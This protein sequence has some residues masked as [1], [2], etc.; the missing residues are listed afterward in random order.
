[1]KSTGMNFFKIKKTIVNMIPG[2]LPFLYYLNPKDLISV[3]L[4]LLK[5]HPAVSLSRRFFIVRQLY[6]ISYNV[7][8]RH[9]ENEMVSFIKAILS[10]P[11]STPGCIIEAGCYK[12]GSTAKFSNAA[13]IMN[14]RLVIFDSFEGLPEHD[15]A[16]DGDTSD[17]HSHALGSFSASLDEVRSNVDKYGRLEV[18]EFVKGW[19]NETMP[20]F[21]EPVAAVFL[22]VDLASSTRTCIIHLFPLV[23]AGGILF[24]NDGYS[25]SVC[26]VFNDDKFWQKEVGYSKPPIQGLG[27]QKL[28]KIIKQPGDTR[29][30]ID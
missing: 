5:P 29:F 23:S 9:A 18:C 28:L 7:D 3:F 15:K 10:I 19:F 2:Q 14:R 8:C 21:S 11:E 16:L 30:D 17:S 27:R 4:F 22:D 12:G 6:T 25:Q 1:M 26:K 13:K 20:Y 24:S